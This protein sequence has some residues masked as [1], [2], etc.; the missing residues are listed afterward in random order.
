MKIK[1]LIKILAF[2][3][4]QYGKD[5]CYALFNSEYYFFHHKEK[6]VFLA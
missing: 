6:N 4:V 1:P 5:K 2:P 3:F